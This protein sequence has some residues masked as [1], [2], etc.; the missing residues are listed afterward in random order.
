MYSE[1]IVMFALIC[2]VVIGIMTSIL[3]DAIKMKSYGRWQQVKVW[4]AMDLKGNIIRAQF[5]HPSQGVKD[6]ERI[7]QASRGENIDRRG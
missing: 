7:L 2:G 6:A 4:V 5:E 3:I 1:T